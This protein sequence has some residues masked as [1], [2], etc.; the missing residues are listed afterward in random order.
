MAKHVLN[1]QRVG[2]LPDHFPAEISAWAPSSTDASTFS[3]M[4][5]NGKA[6]RTIQEMASPHGGI[7]DM[8]E[9]LCEDV[10][11]CPKMVREWLE[12]PYTD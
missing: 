2:W 11:L 10:A 7:V 4:S 6:S 5:M 8:V 1:L 12:Y 3:A 9:E